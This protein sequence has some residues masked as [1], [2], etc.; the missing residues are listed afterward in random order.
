VSFAAAAPRGDSRTLP[1]VQ[2]V[3]PVSRPRSNRSGLVRAARRPV[4]D[5]AWWHGGS[6]WRD[7][8]EPPRPL[9]GIAWHRGRAPPSGTSWA[10]SAGHRFML[11][12]QRD[13]VPHIARQL[14]ACNGCD[15]LVIRVIKRGSI[16]PEPPIDGL[17][18]ILKAA[19]IVVTHRYPHSHGS[20]RWSAALSTDEGRGRPR[21]GLE[22][23]KE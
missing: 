16:S 9:P 23:W 11:G 14:R 1:T 5:P 19:T 3:A 20:S 18:A 8:Q 2:P 17:T 15:H 22:A 4:T 6:G 13:P 21:H 10:L 12:Q 7:R